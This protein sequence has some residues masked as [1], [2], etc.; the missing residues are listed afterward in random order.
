MK[1]VPK[2]MEQYVFPILAGATSTALSFGLIW[3]L[4]LVDNTFIVAKTNTYIGLL[5][6][7][8]TF[9]LAMI[10]QFINSQEMHYMLEESI[11]ML[12]LL[13]VSGLIYSFLPEVNFVPF[14]MFAGIY[15]VRSLIKKGGI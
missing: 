8:I 11:N 2:Q 4:K 10:I 15:F 5:T 12:L 1:I 6:F 13:I 3:F 7:G 9:G 14:T